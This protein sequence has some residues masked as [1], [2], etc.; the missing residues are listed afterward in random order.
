MRRFNLLWKE[1]TQECFSFQK[2]KVF[3]CK[4]IKEVVCK[5]LRK[6]NDLVMSWW[7]EARE[8]VGL[9]PWAS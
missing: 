8:G 1:V 5:T 3:R 9:K 2:V 7:D 4:Q 6:M